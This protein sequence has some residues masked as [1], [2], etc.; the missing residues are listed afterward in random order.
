MS[1]H[2]SYNNKRIAKNTCCLLSDVIY[3]EGDRGKL[4]TI[5]VEDPLTEGK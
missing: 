4:N 1:N 5:F 3:D 2:T